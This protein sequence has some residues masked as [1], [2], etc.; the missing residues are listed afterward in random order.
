MKFFKQIISIYRE[1]GF[2][3]LIREKGWLVALLLFCFFLGKGLVWL[4]IAKGG[5]EL[6]QNLF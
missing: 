5:M 2:K 1:K 6:I 4:A 3:T